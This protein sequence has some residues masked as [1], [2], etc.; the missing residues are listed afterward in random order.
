MN[1]CPLTGLPCSLKKCIHVTEVDKDYN[2]T[3]I[4][5]HCLSCGLPI[6]S[7]DI[8][9]DIPKTLQK[10]F[11]NEVSI[12]EVEPL[13]Q[14]NCSCGFTMIDLLKSSKLGCPECYMTFYE[15]LAPVIQM[16]HKKGQ[17]IGKKPKNIEKSL[18]TLE[19][20]LKEAVEKE[21]YE[22]AAKIRDQIRLIHQSEQI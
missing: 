12:L 6:F 9:E 8:G 14:K 1:T 4:N 17:H 13:P 10:I 19:V 15:E 16:I 3:Q 2:A 18:G 11:H 21:D 5:H 22:L 20:E 7:K